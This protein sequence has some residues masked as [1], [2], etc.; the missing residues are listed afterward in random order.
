MVFRHRRCGQRFRATVT[1]SACGEA[2]RTGEA[3]AL[4]GPGARPG[5]GTRVLDEILAQRAAQT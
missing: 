1:C 4:P 5:P 2:P 3:E